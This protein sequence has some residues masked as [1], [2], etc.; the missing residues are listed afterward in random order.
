M[1]WFERKPRNRRDGLARRAAVAGVLMA[2]AVATGCTVRPLYGDVTAATTQRGGVSAAKLAA[3][4][5]RPIEDRVAQEVRNHLIFLFNGGAGQ[6]ASPL[7][8][9][10]LGVRTLRASAATVQPATDDL[11]PTA[12]VVTLRGSYVLSDARTGDRISAGVRSVQA[13]YDIS[14][15]AFAA[16]R[17]E[18]DAQ[19]RAARELAELLRLVIAQELENPT[20]KA[21]PAVVST[22]AELEGL[23]EEEEQGSVTVE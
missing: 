14:R 2:L 4:D 18:R 21:E 7:Y 19:N 23:S 20:S 15:Q 1:S 9:L 13:S 12:A 16:L 8:T 5:I 10:D 6:P 3:I 11:E 17:A 22:P